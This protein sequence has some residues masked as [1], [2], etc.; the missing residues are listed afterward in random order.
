MAQW[1]VALAE[2]P[3]DD[4]HPYFCRSSWG[5]VDSILWLAYDAEVEPGNAEIF[6]RALYCRES[7]WREP[8]R[9]TFDP[10]TDQNPVVELVADSAVIVWE[11]NRRGNWDLMYA[12][13]GQAGWS[14]AEFVTTD[15]ADER[16]PAL[17][18]SFWW[19]SGRWLSRVLLVYSRGG[20]LFIAAF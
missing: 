1:F 4:R 6:V 19:S 11:S 13:H 18:S 2:S 12:T 15:S 7:A 9:L 20:V 5:A 14:A 16:E 8:L 17:A 10:A 3:N